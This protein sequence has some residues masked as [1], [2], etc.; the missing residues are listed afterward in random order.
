MPESG[1]SG[2]VGAVG[3]QSPAATRHESESHFEDAVYECRDFYIAEEKVEVELYREFHQASSGFSGTS[4]IR[5]TAT[6]RAQKSIKRWM[7]T[8]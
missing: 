2:S 5:Q 1:T 4:G 3:E 8:K 6:V 7:A